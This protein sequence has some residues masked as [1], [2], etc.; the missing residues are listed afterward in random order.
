[1]E[2]PDNHRHTNP[3]GFSNY[4]EYQYGHDPIVPYQP[5]VIYH[6]ESPRF[7]GRESEQKLRTKATRNDNLTDDDDDDDDDDDEDDDAKADRKERPRLANK[8]S[9]QKAYEREKNAHENKKTKKLLGQT[10]T[11][12]APHSRRHDQRTPSPPS[13]QKFDPYVHRTCSLQEPT[14]LS[15]RPRAGVT[16]SSSYHAGLHDATQ[17][18]YKT[19][20]YQAYAEDS[21]EDS[22]RAPPGSWRDV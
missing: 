15:T 17:A 22:P 3:S 13:T 18:T 19:R 12:Q 20:A 14:R 9:S 8:K 6:H 10:A 4:S 2:S 16:R 7:P 11:Q 1:M 21:P 5:T